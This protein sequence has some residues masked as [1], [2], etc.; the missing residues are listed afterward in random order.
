M[1]SLA[2]AGLS[3]SSMSLSSSWPRMRSGQK[4]PFQNAPGPFIY[5]L[6]NLAGT[7]PFS[8]SPDT[9]LFCSSLGA[10]DSNNAPPANPHHH[11]HHHHCRCCCCHHD[12]PSPPSESTEL[13]TASTK[14]GSAPDSTESPLLAPPAPYAS[15]LSPSS[16]SH[17]DLGDAISSPSP[18][19]GGAEPGRQEPQASET[20]T[21][22]LTP[23]QSNAL[24]S[25]AESDFQ[26]GQKK[27]GDLEEV[28]EK[29]GGGRRKKR[30]RYRRQPRGGPP[31]EYG[32]STIAPRFMGLS[33]MHYASGLWTPYVCPQAPPPAM[34]Y[35]H[36][37][38]GGGF[39][40]HPNGSAPLFCNPMVPAT[41]VVGVPVTSC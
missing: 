10:G 33:G 17:C 15:S 1:E 32:V 35:Y 16:E 40:V 12:S 5:A 27:V 7:C 31:H 36:Q 29:K 41:G 39:V 23:T 11:R 28:R 18:I 34:N 24:S 13:P 19:E 14:E 6:P 26:E 30:R 4:N 38:P 20:S 22:P 37:Y 2:G 21:P 8:C 9:D 25:P 3:S